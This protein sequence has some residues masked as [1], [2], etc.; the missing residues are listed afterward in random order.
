MRWGSFLSNRYIILNH[1]H[2]VSRESPMDKTIS[3]RIF[4]LL[5][6]IYLLMVV[7]NSF[8]PQGLS[9]SLVPAAQTPASPVVMALANA[10]IVLVLY[11]GLGFL[12]LSLWRK[13]DLPD[14]WTVTVSNRQRFLIPALVGLGSGIFFILI[15]LMFSPINGI[16]RLTHPPFPT[17]I[18]ASISAGIGEEIV[19]RLFFISF[20]TWLVSQVVLRAR[21]QTQVY[22]VFSFLSAIAFSMAHLPAFMFLQGWSDLSQVPPMLFVELLLL[23]STL[24]LLA[25]YFFKK[26]GFLAPVGIHF[27]SDMIWH[28]LWGLL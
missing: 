14:I 22:A 12:G 1:N 11:G 7:L 25:A 24:S 9:G 16:G 28:A 23:N 18:V 19:F 5:V 20:W 10:G 13:L 26:Y 3:N 17:S 15:D 27:W 6:V 21:W 4:V 8:L 2:M